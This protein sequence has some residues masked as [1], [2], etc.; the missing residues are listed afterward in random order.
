MPIFTLQFWNW[1]DT[2]K[3][4]PSDFPFPDDV[5][6]VDNQL[7]ISGDSRRVPRWAGSVAIAGTLR[8]YLSSLVTMGTRVHI[9]K[10]GALWVNMPITA[11]S[12]GWSA[13]G[14]RDVSVIEFESDEARLAE[15]EYIAG[16]P[17]A[18]PTVTNPGDVGKAALSFGAALSATGSAHDVPT[19]L[20]QAAGGYA[21]LAIANAITILPYRNLLNWF[22]EVGNL[23]ECPFGS[24]LQGRLSY[25]PE[26]DRGGFVRRSD[27][28]ADLH[29]HDINEYFNGVR[30]ESSRPDGTSVQYTAGILLPALARWHKQYTHTVPTAD[31]SSGDIAR[32]A[33]AIQKRAV[34]RYHT[35]TI[36]VHPRFDLTIG[37][38]IAVEESSGY[39]SHV[40]PPYSAEDGT[41]F[42]PIEQMTMTS[43]ETVI[44]Q[45]VINNV[46]RTAWA[47]QRLRVPPYQWSDTPGNWYDPA[48]IT[49]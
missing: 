20:P 31:W 28:R 17:W 22:V 18:I 10:D 48:T 14:G 6:I 34:I 32:I 30:V 5:T 16:S 42:G 24:D 12:A 19:F 15:Q 46:Y 33:F 38:Q 21:P 35:R 40:S 36:R 13:D 3:I 26:E 41:T 25:W 29:R 47:Q 27:I 1:A 45:R 4:T 39:Y 7:S 11:I 37:D 44:V 9:L 8:P 49:I 2:S 23:I 43:D